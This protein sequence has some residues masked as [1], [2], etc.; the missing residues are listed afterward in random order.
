MF[1]DNNETV[2]LSGEPICTIHTKLIDIRFYFVREKVED[3]TIR[4]GGSCRVQE[5]V[6]PGYCEDFP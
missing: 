6:S 5:A 3:G 1:E 2:E 4:M